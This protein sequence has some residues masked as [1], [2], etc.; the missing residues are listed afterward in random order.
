[1]VY[2]PPVISLTALQE[3]DVSLLSALER[4]NLIL[5]QILK[6]EDLL[7][8]AQAM[9]MSEREVTESLQQ[10]LEVRTEF[11]LNN[12]Q[13]YQTIILARLDEAYRDARSFAYRVVI[14]EKTGEERIDPDIHWFREM[15]K[16]NDSIAKLLSG[17]ADNGKPNVTLI[18]PTILMGDDLY[19]KAQSLASF[20]D[21]NPQDLIEGQIIDE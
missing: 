16:V 11:Y 7:D 2:K 9:Q 6:G 15:L 4:Q 21:Q 18:N 14:D 19:R 3:K 1:M 20:R 17:A 10:A 8:V 5:Q 13:Q 12:A